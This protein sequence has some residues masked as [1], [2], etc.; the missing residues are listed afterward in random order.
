L[1]IRLAIETLPPFLMAGVRF[2]IA[3]VVLYGW[4]R[5]RGAP[6]PVRTHWLAAATAGGLMLL[7]GNGGVV[8]AEQRVPSG[9]TAVLIATVPL[10]IALLEWLQGGAR[11]GGRVAGGLMMGLAGIALLVGPGE[12]AGGKGIDLVG[13]AVLLVASLSWAMGSLYS[14]R[15][16][17]PSSPL[18]STA[19]E[20][21]G[22]GLLL[23][24]AGLV[25]GQASDLDLIH[26]SL[27]SVLAL[28][29]LIAFG[30]LVAFTAYVWLLRVTLPAQAATYAYVNPVVAVFLGWALG[31]E[32]LTA[33]TLL[34]AAVIVGAVV[35]ITSSQPR[36]SR[37]AA[38]GS[39]EVPLLAIPVPHADLAS[40]RGRSSGMT[41]PAPGI[42]P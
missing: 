30:S 38:A 31:G 27:Q 17:L 22:G 14:R 34:A 26:I 25:T 19:M 5:W 7:G 39:E 29:Y 28:C 3:G 24:L 42:G 2:I 41:P 23:L 15:A 40:D 36:A 37:E 35:I 16:R 20:M 18:L 33:R 10:W 21:L 11:P 12:L 8:W 9:L 4:A 1:A 6:R 32:P 13:A